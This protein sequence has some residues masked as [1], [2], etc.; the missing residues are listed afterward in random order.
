MSQKMTYRG[1]IHQIDKAQT[2][3]SGFAK[4]IVVC[5]QE[6]GVSKFPDYAVFEFV[7]YPSTE[8]AKDATVIPDQ[9]R[10]GDRVKIDFY[11]QANENRNKP[12][13]WFGACRAVA[14]ERD[15]EQAPMNLVGGAQ[16]MPEPPENAD[17]GAGA[18][19]E[20]PF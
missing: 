17:G 3:P 4:R 14:M 6:D 11:L 5:R 1:T 12:G 2:F 15:G 20:L 19:D 18:V 8:R 7:K 9:F 13:Q 16:D 10:V